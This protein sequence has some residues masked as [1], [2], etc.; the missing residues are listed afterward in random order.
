M[1]PSPIRDAV[2]VL[3]NDPFRLPF[4]LDAAALFL[5]ALSGA[6][7][8]RERGY[9]VM[10]VLSMA[11]VTG[12]GGGILRDVLLGR[13]PLLLGEP[14]FL[15]VA[16]AAALMGA[17]LG[18]RFGGRP[19]RALLE[20]S[21]ALG[22]ALY[23][24]VGALAGVWAGLSVPA[25]AL[26]GTVNATGGGLLRDVLTREEPLIFRPGQWYAGVALTAA[27]LCAGLV[28]YG[29]VRSLPAGVAAAALGFG[30][31]LLVM[32]FDWRTRPLLPATGGTVG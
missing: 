1:P 4:W 17:L 13:R 29:H 8:A 5:F 32:R 24:V 20:L 3:L 26:L 22:L 21:D 14:R 31:R 10:G 28:L 15:V 25:A 19:T 23:A 7:R 30:L 16:C 6:L 18:R 27:A 12:G 9:D 11:L 2:Y